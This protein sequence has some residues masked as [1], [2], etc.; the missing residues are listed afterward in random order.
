MLTERS[1]CLRSYRFLVL[2]IRPYTFS[3]KL[4]GLHD[5]VGSVRPQSDNKAVQYSLSYMNADSVQH[6]AVLQR[7]RRSGKAGTGA[8]KYC[9]N[10][11]H[12]VVLAAAAAS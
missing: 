12:S 3:H 11:M 10:L 6:A 1:C 5:T 4:V 7:E 2:G 8:F 9:C